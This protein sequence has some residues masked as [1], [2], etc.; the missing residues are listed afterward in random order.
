MEC[1]HYCNKTENLVIVNVIECNILN[2]IYRAASD[3]FSC[4]F[5]NLYQVTFIGID[6][7][8]PA[9]SPCY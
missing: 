7:L 2:Y 1:L 4:E 6:K 9:Y 8:L 3:P 5:L